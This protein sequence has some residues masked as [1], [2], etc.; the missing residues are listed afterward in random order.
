MK[1]AVT[2]YSTE[3]IG[4]TPQI[5]LKAFSVNDAKIFAKLEWYNNFGSIKDRP[6]SWMVSEAEKHGL[7]KRGKSVIM[8]PTSGNTGIALAGIA[9]A[10]GYRFEVVIPNKVSDETKAILKRF[11]V[12]VLETED[13]L[14]PRVGPGTDQSIALATAIVRGHPGDYF[15]PNQYENDANFMAHYYGTGS[16]IW[17][18]TE[19][20]VT[21]F[22]A[23]IGTGGTIT[24]VGKFLKEKNPNIRIIAVEPQ[25]GHHIQ[26]LRNTGESNLPT[27]LERR[28][29]VID[30]WLEIKDDEAFATVRAIVEKE[31]MFVG[32]SSGAVLAAALKVAKENRGARIV[33]IFGDDGRKYRS[34]YSQFKVFTDAEF[35]KLSKTAKNLP[36]SPIFRN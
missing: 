31:N 22:V 33:A 5:E 17:R 16:E 14:C 28:K 9:K 15:M 30:Q 21:H 4:N 32:P 23:G 7:L 19:G 20:K 2:K 6:A 12:K 29:E 35:D 10:L 24:G 8:E 3:N 34:V 25:K 11:D 27:L 26:G 18:D 36:N 13:D 1:T